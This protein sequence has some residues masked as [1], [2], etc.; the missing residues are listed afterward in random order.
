MLAA[1]P[2][3]AAEPAGERIRRL[4][5]ADVI[6]RVETH[7]IAAPQQHEA[8]DVIMSWLLDQN[9]FELEVLL[10]GDSEPTL[11]RVGDL[12]AAGL[13]VDDVVEFLRNNG[14]PDELAS[15]EERFEFLGNVIGVVPEH[16][17]VMASDESE[18]AGKA[19]I[20]TVRWDG[21]TPWGA[22]TGVTLTMRPGG[23]PAGSQPKSDPTWI[24]TV[25]GHL[26]PGGNT[27]IYV[28]GHLLN[29]NIGG[30]GLDYNMV[31][32]T[33]KAAK[34]AGGNDANDVHLNVI[35]KEAKA[36]WDAVRGGRLGRAEYSVHAEFGR[37]PRAAT[38]RVERQVELLQ[39][40]RGELAEDVREA[41]YELSG[42]EAREE[43]RGRVE[44]RGIDPAAV[45]QING[46]DI[47]SEL[48]DELIVADEMS[49]HGSTLVGELIRTE[50]KVAAVLAGLDLGIARA[51]LN[52]VDPLQ[53]TLDELLGALAGNAAVWRFEEQYVPAALRVSLQKWAT[54]GTRDA[55]H[56]AS[57]PV[58]LPA[59]PAKVY[60]RP[61]KASEDA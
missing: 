53:V 6:R 24:K 44:R 32:L 34:R 61:K 57:V 29:H 39:I 51:S 12:T 13:D 16:L 38:A 60:Y 58:V 31:P 59:D 25:E 46:A 48:V 11:N 20:S 56:T 10:S 41:V 55:P 37:T 27:S 15:A 21:L 26:G 43:L 14:A 42:D 45:L 36:T 35:E 2:A 5:D 19:A 52:G 4:P 7:H 28:R 40:A 30:P 17:T 9:V 18:A 1:A 8:I 47:P 54:D 33:G 50:P 23:I 3:P 22:G 49:A